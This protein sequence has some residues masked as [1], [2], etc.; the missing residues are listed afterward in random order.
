[1]TNRRKLV[2]FSRQH[3]LAFP[4]LLLSV[5][6]CGGPSNW[7]FLC[8]ALHY[9]FLSQNPYNRNMNPK[10]P[11]LLCLLAAGAYYWSTRA[12]RRV[13]P[14]PTQAIGAV[15]S[16]TPIPFESLPASIAINANEIMAQAA[17]LLLKS[18]ALHAKARFKVDLMGQQLAAPGEYWQQGE[19]S[20][21]TRLEFRY[22][23]EGSRLDALQICDGRYF[24]WY[25]IVNAEGRL[26]Y[27]DLKQVE[28]VH[29]DDSP[30]LGGRRAWDTVGGLSSMMDHIS[31][32]FDFEPVSQATLDGIPVVVIRGRWKQD[33]LARLMEGQ[34]DAARLVDESWWKHL[35]AHLPHAVQFTIGTEDP[36]PFFPYRVE[37]LQFE[38]QAEKILAKPVVTLE[39]YEVEALSE[40]PATLF[41]VAA[42]RCEPIDVTQFYLDRV[43]QFT[44][45]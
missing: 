33:S 30:F 24:Y 38:M 42:V 23:S 11:L 28:E 14:T 1:M 3:C 5:S 6:N 15:E 19:G 29:H 26:E 12:Y 37:F 40:I 34:V 39:L 35:P 44:R 2:D 9:V 7:L 21:R 20:R 45:R 16:S 27:I 43:H 4:K 22:Q 8:S 31:K 13:E 25:R 18:P 10:L 17:D 41:Q 32:A 36:F